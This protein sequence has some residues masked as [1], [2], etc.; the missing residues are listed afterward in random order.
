[1]IDR[2]HK[3]LIDC[4]LIVTAILIVYY[5]VY[6]IPFLYYEKLGIQY[7][8]IVTNMGV[9]FEK[10]LTWKGLFQRPLSMFT[11]TLNYYFNG[12]NTAY[13][14]LVNLLIHV[15]NSIL[16]YFIAR[17]LLNKNHFFAAL[18]FALHPLA[19]ACAS[20][21][22][23]RIYSLGTLFMFLFFLL[24]LKW[25]EE[26][27][28]TFAKVFA[29]GTI[30]ILMVLSKQSLIFLPLIVLWY[31]VYKDNLRFNSR[32]YIVSAISLAMI[33]LFTFIYALPYSEKA[34]V[35]PWTFFLSQMGNLTTLIGLYLLP[36]Q[37]A[38]LHELSFYGSLYPEVIFGILIAAALVYVAFK[39]RK[40]DYGFLLGAFLIS[41]FP[42]NSFMPKD[43]VIQEW[44]LYPSLI[45]F[46]ILF[47]CI[48]NYVF[49]NKTK[50]YY[51]LFSCYIL[52]FSYSIIRQ[53]HAYGSE[54]TAW[55]QVVKRHPSS[56]SFNNL[57]RAYAIE[58][59]F[60]LAL[61][62]FL[63]AKEADPTNYAYY[64]NIAQVYLDTGNKDM[65][66]SYLEQ[67]NIVGQNYGYKTH[68]YKIQE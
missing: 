8:P 20:K 60:D 43:D 28:I 44:R 53:N 62:N 37:T 1:M 3:A 10:M 64:K 30:F 24:Y 16:V 47:V 38:L 21:L 6:S 55:E 7:N 26:N 42:T 63:K 17:R 49:R 34:I 19:T 4:S 39:N 52:L 14:H 65:A 41:I 5:S 59:K 12:Q 22:H 46:S 51:I 66:K 56:D 18:L 67:S 25:R 32:F 50:L 33:L 2:R 58:G 15:V 13:Y 29:L 36:F 31:E 61:E 23:G 54:V 68:S 40:K 57:G 45:F 27:K 48:L 35:G 11:Y 9:F